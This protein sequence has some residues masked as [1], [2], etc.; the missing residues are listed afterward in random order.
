MALCSTSDAFIAAPMDSFSNAAKLAFLVFGPMLD[1]KLV[2]MYSS[3]FRRKFLVGLCAAIFLLVALLCE[4]WA[5][6]VG[7]LSNKPVPTAVSSMGA[8][9]PAGAPAAAP[10]SPPAPASAVSPSSSTEAKP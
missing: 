3:V 2:F 5:K 10:A 4:P 9:G 7:K 1:V 6:W 8:G